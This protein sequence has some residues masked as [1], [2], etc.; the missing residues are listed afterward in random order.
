MTVTTPVIRRFSGRSII[1]LANGQHLQVLPDMT[2]LSKCQKYQSA[3]FISNIGTLVV[4]SDD[5][6]EIVDRITL[7]ERE[8]LSIIWQADLGAASE[9]KKETV[10]VDVSELPSSNVS[11]SELEAGKGS[12]K[13]P[14][15]K[16]IQPF[17]IACSIAMVF[18]AMGSGLEKLIVQAS[19]DKQYI[20]FGLLLT[21]P[22]L[23]WFSLVRRCLF[24]EST[25]Y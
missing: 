7:L 20:R 25:T 9:E 3:A 11:I 22:F 14:R 12:T 16:I 1:S 19:W 21:V 23:T 6:V 4:W 10:S 8:L 15:L 5:P 13:R 2:W 24:W 17:G 18:S